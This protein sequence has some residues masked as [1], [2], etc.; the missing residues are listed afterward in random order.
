MQHARHRQQPRHR[1]QRQH[2]RRLT[3]AVLATG[4][5]AALAPALAPALAGGGGSPAAAAAD[6]T[7]GYS[8][9]ALTVDVLVGPDRDQPCTVAAD[10]Y[11]PDGVSRHDRAP[12]ILTTHGF[13]GAKDDENQTATGSGFAREGYVV[14]SYSGLGFGG[15]GCKI[16][17]DDPDWDGAAG[18][19]L[20]S[21]LAGKRAATDEATGAPVHVRTVAREAPGD[22]RVGMIGGS[23]GG[24][25]QFAVA[26]QDPRVDALIP[27]ITWNDLSYSLAPNNT[28]PAA[29]GQVRSPTP[30]VF[31][32]EWSGFFFGLGIADGISG[33]SVDPERNVGCPNFADEVC[34]A[35]AQMTALG[36]P[37]KATR[38]LAR[39]A[40]VA[41]YV[42][43]IDVPTLLVQG[44]ADTLFDL[45]EAVA[46]YRSLRRQGTEARMVW[47]SWGHSGG[48]TPAP[49]ELEL[50]AGGDIADSYLGRRFLA[51]MDHWVAGERSAPVG[52]RFAYFR[53]WVDYD[54]SPG[55]AGHAVAKA[56][57]TSDHF[58]QSP[59]ATLY[60]SGTDA[61]VRRRANVED[62]AAAY[63]NAPGAPTSYS[64]TSAL[65]GVYVDNPPTDAPGTIA[66]WSTAPLAEPAVIVGSPRLRLHLDAP[67]VEVGQGADPA[68]KLV[69][70]AKLYDVAS[71]GSVTLQHRLISPVR[72]RDVTQPVSVT[73]PG[74]VQRIP[75]GHTLR[76]VVA[77]SD[78][79]Y[80]GNAAVHP[81]QVVTSA[82][83]P[84]TLRLP[85]T[86]PL[87]LG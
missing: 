36:Y 1:R 14:L 66:Q 52:P 65:E 84:G 53:D 83:H 58:D 67:T 57:A 31:K 54:T 85:L 45:Q 28:D 70:F 18:K 73:L 62:G 77:A 5:A 51:W 9:R 72:V 50:T 30:G 39:H 64:E 47:Q 55:A 22:P 10:L 19:Q 17:L 13:G 8:L 61:L 37:D 74:V 86:T 79:A 20:V 63:A 34:T 27:L 40:S 21:V 69:L 4:L 75:A 26:M 35:L 32:R 71:D 80:G 44:Q 60:L 25:I 24:Q 6:A 56:Y 46:T 33:A 12:A 49:G 15:S 29:A 78:A 38:H 7:P 68:G 23:Y 59:T 82:A 87:R 3:A 81:V 76:L 11:T 41:S 42:H 2:P 48:G 16:H 43:R